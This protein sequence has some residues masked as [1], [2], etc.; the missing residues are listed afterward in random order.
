MRRGAGA[1]RTQ[2][3]DH[4]DGGRV[5]LQAGARDALV[6]TVLNVDGVV[7]ARGISQRGGEIYL[8]GGAQRQRDGERH[9]G[10][11]RHR[12][13][14]TA[15]GQLRVLGENVGLIGGAR[16]DASGDAGGGSVLV[17]GNYQGSGPEHNATRAFV[18]SGVT[19]NADARAAATAA[20]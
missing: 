20:G 14:G 3:A 16:L 13:D 8:D 4:A 17:G 11:V 19:I 9:A 1:G 7:R 5:A 6:D 10:R 18:G 15:G 12:A 2:R